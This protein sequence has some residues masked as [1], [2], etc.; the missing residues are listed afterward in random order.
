MTDIILCKLGEIVL[1]GLNRKSFELKLMG[2]MC[3]RLAP[4]GKF[5]VYCLQ[6]TTVRTTRVSNPV[7]YP[8]FRALASVEDSPA[9]FA[10]G[11]LRDLF[12]TLP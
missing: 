7:R 2:N 6:S 4:L 8:H 12:G 9:A 5:R 1:K 11:V 10:I 3:R